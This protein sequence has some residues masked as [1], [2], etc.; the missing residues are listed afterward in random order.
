[1]LTKLEYPGGAVFINPENV[2][3]IGDALDPNGRPMI[4]TCTVFLVGGTALALPL[5]KETCVA[6]LTRS[7]AVNGCNGVCSR[8]KVLPQ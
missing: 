5:T 8:G 3:A 1:M 4:G 2:A 7:L 6:T